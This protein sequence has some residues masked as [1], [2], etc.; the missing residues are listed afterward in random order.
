MEQNTIIEALVKALTK[1]SGSLDDLENLLNRAQKD[2]AAAKEE[3]KRQEAE[4]NA[5]RGAYVAE[6]ATRL[7]NDE[8]TDDDCAFVMN[9]WLRTHGIKR[10]DFKSS[11]LKEIMSESKETAVNTFIDEDL[12]KVLQDLANDIRSWTE[13]LAKDCNRKPEKKPVKK[14]PTDADSVINDFLKSFGLR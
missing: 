10:A 7:L 14:D 6:L 12:P 2:V 1:G 3:Q 5:K 8:I 11:D 9:A 4:A 13:N